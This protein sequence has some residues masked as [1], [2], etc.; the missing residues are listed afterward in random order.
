MPFAKLALGHCLSSPGTRKNK[1]AERV[2][3]VWI[4]KCTGL[5]IKLEWDEER[6]CLAWERGRVESPEHLVLL[7]NE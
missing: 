4:S 2:L 3:T 5:N 6:R 1:K 7:K